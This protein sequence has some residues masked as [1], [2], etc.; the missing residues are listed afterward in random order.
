MNVKHFYAGKE[1]TMT[2]KHR[3]HWMAMA[4]ILEQFARFPA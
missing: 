3:M 4:V 2:R 1:T